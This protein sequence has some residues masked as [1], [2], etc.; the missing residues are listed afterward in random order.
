MCVDGALSDEQPLGDLPVRQACGDEFR[1]LVLAG[2]EDLLLLRE[3]VRR[4]L[5]DR[6]EGSAD[7]LATS[8]YPARLALGGYLGPR[9]SSYL[10]CYLVD[11]C[12]DA[13][14]RPA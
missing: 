12:L 7:T 10:C 9:R 4:R 2:G 3:A 6:R 5:Y 11:G 13:R 8:G 14:K 1:D